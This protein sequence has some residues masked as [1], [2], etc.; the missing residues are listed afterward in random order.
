MNTVNLGP[1]W[2]ELAEEST[3]ELA[4]E[5]GKSF[6]ELKAQRGSSPALK[7]N[8]TPEEVSGITT[9]LLLRSD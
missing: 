7:R 9:F 3:A 1:I 4:K 5:T 6:E 2:A 8:G